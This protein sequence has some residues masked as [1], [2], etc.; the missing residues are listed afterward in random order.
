MKL[1]RELRRGKHADG[2]AVLLMWELYL[3]LLR[4]AVRLQ[5]LGERK[6]RAH[7]SVIFGAVCG[8]VGIATE[9]SLRTYLY[10]T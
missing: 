1:A 5:P 6:L 9:S 3:P 8:D 7:H 4:C 2:K 10:S